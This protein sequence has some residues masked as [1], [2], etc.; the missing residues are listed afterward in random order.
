MATNELFFPLQLGFENNEISSQN[1]YLNPVPHIAEKQFL[2]VESKNIKIAP[3]KAEAR[4]SLKQLCRDEFGHMVDR[5]AQQVF[6]FTPQ[7]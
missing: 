2:F 1:C 5:F 6:V 3:T 4:E 7:F